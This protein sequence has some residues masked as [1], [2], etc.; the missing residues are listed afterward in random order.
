MMNALQIAPFWKT[1]FGHPARGDLGLVNAIFPIGKV[2]GLAVVTWMSDKYGRRL[3]IIVG[4]VL[5]IAGAGVQASSVN[6][7]MFIFSRWLVGSVQRS[8]RNLAQCLLPS[9]PSLRIA[10]KLRHYSIPFT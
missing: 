4:T 9:W 3:P 5:C 2:C 8:W 6:F 1:Y 7:A 10:Q